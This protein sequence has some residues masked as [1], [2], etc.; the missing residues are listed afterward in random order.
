MKR[1]SLAERTQLARERA[2][3]TILG[4][5][6]ASGG[7]LEGK[8][9]LYK[10]FYR[11]H[12]NYFEATGLEL[13]GYPIV[14]MPNGPGIDNAQELIDE[15]SEA[16][17]LKETIG[18]GTKLNERVYEVIG[19]SCREEDPDK[20]AAIAAAVKWAKTLSEK[21]LKDGSH[22]R[23]WREG[24]SGKEQNIYVD[25]LPPERV[26]QIRREAGKRLAGLE[27]LVPGL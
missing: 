8:L 27:K 26:E 13:T 10:A 20:V 2:K 18:N 22:N 4:L 6:D 15:L 17:L 3:R 5:L 24:I 16:G 19:D 14:H 9:R 23:S 7:R 12:L 1:R 11:A 21:Q 25:E